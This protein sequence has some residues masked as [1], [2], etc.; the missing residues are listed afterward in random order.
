M[1]HVALTIVL[2]LL[3]ALTLFQIALICGAPWGRLAWGGAHRVLPAR[4]RVGSGVSILLY[5]AFAVVLLA[6][7]GALP[8]EDSA[9]VV[10]LTWV[11]FAYFLAGIVLNG[12]SRSRPE[13]WTMTPVCA[14]LAGMTLIVALS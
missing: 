4:L 1:M 9:V 12:I 14:M 13:R 5:A 11:L 7:S 3:T 10:V 8:G 2:A 6:R